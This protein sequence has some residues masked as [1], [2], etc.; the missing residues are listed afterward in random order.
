MDAECSPATVPRTTTGDAGGGIVDCDEE[1]L[2][3]LRRSHGG[4][5][6]IG[7]TPETGC[8]AALRGKIGHLLTAGTPELLEAKIVDDLAARPVPLEP[9][10]E[11]TP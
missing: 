6:T 11:A 4:A 9:A 8:F 7:F 10:A 1:A 2:T 5:Y 3:A